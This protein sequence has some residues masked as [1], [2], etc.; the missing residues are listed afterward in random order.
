MKHLLAV[1]GSSG[2]GKVFSGM[3]Q[4]RGYAVSVL[5]LGPKRS[6]NHIVCDVTEADH[7]LTGVDLA[8]R[9]HGLISGLAFF[10]RFRGSG[11][12]SWDGELATQLTG[13]RRV[14]EVAFPWKAE[15]ASVVIT[16]SATASF[17]TE[18][19]LCGYHVAKAGLVQLTRVYANKWGFDGVRVN[20]VCPGTFIKPENAQHFRDS[21]DETARLSRA[22]PLGRMLDAREVAEVILFLLSDAASGITG[23]AITVDGGVGLRW[24]EDLVT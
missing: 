19:M 8:R 16:A 10:Q 18:K 5:A 4:E 6:E 11:D 1:G 13:T 24:Q 3:A 15:K 2:L 20:C 9:N 23:Q 17:V 7:V 22:S 21:P 12:H 14:L